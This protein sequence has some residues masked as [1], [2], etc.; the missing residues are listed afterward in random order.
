MPGPI[1]GAAPRGRYDTET[2]ECIA[3]D[4]KPSRSSRPSAAS[5]KPEISGGFCGAAPTLSDGAKKLVQSRRPP[6]LPARSGGTQGSGGTS[7]KARSA[8]APRR[9][10]SSKSCATPVIGAAAGCVGAAAATAVSTAT[11]PGALVVLGASGA[12]CGVAVMNAADC[13][14]DEP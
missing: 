6:T 1:C 3:D 5:S 4:A 2:N 11:G 12:A 9:A 13:L 8:P 10:E 14:T 7:G